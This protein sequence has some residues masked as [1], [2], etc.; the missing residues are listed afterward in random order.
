MVEKSG[1][2]KFMVDIFGVEKFRVE[3]SWVEKFT[4][5][6]SG[7][8]ISCSQ[9]FMKIVDLPALV[10]ILQILCLQVIK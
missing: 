3:K 6:K 10:G 9:I 5:E 1:V 2:G 8:E 7:I 4:I